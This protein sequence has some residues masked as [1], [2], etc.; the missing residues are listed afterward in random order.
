MYFIDL[1]WFYK[2]L[3]YKFYTAMML[4]EFCIGLSTVFFMINAELGTHWNISGD[5]ASTSTMELSHCISRDAML[6]INQRHR[7]VE[8]DREARDVITRLKLDRRRGCRAGEHHR[9]RVHAAQ[10]VTSSVRG[11]ALRQ[12]IPS[13]VGNRTNNVNSNQLIKK[14]LESSVRVP[15]LVTVQRS[16]TCIACTTDANRP[17]TTA[18]GSGRTL[19]FVPPALYV[20]NAAAVTK[21][22]AISHLTADLLGYNIDVGIITETHLK[23]NHADHTVSVHGFNLFR[24]DRAKRR[25]GGVAVYVSN[26]LSA[27]LWTPA[28]DHSDYELLWVRVQFNSYEAV[29]GALYHPPK[30]IYAVSD[31]LCHIDA[32]LD[33][34]ASDMPSAIVVIAGDFNSLSDDDFVSRTALASL[35]T[36]PTR[37]LNCLDRIYTNDACYKHV[38]VVTSAVKSDHCAVIA[39]DDDIP[40]FNINK[41][42]QVRTCRKRTPTQ[43]DAFL[44]FASRENIDFCSTDDVQANFDG[45]YQY[46]QELLNRF[47]P[48]R[49]VTIT[50][51]DPHFVTPAVKSM[52]R[53][54]NRLMRSGRV[55]EAAAI[56]KRVRSVITRNN[57]LH[58][59]NNDTRRNVRETWSKVRE[60]TRGRSYDTDATDSEF[61]ADALNNHYASISTDAAYVPT[62]RKQTVSN[63]DQFVTEMDVFHMLD[64]LK[65]TAA[66][67][68]G[69]PEW[70]LRVSA[71]VFAAPL[72]TLMNQSIAEGVVP[73]QWKTALI[74]PV[75]KV[76]EPTSESDYRPISITSILS[77]LVERRIVT[78]YIYP[79][80]QS[81]PPQLYFA[82]QY[83][84]RPTG[85]TTAAL[86]ALL[87]TICTMLSANPFVRVFAIDF[88]KAFDSIR[89]HQL[90]EKLSF[91]TIPDEIYNWVENFFSGRDHC[92]RFR[93]EMSTFACISASVVQ[94]SALGPASY[95]ITAANLRPV[96]SG[97]AIF[98]YA[99]DTY[100]VVPAANDDTCDEELKH[101]QAWADDN[102]L[103]MNATKS[104]E[105]I[106]KPRGARGKSLQLPPPF[107]TIERVTKMTVLGVIINDRLTSTDHVTELLV[108]CTKLIYAMRVLRTYGLPH[109]SLQDVFRATVEA[110]L[111]YA[112]PAWSGFST[113]ADR[114]RINSF[115]RRCL[116]LG[117][118]DSDSPDVDCMFADSDE[119]FFDRIKHNSRHILQQYLPDRP[120]LNY[121]LR[122]RHHNKTLISKTSELNDRDFII[123]NLYKYSY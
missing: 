76:A 95:A 57:S 110:K 105:I 34:I 9:R 10:V 30:P 83:A 104:K 65:P 72:A 1:C 17:T 61:T 102:N 108:S 22:H 59:H 111:L 39:Y 41:R 82:D 14:R 56:A 109:Q 78:S 44:Q 20:L 118:R 68:D 116:K 92:T 26:R 49:Q 90:L 77:R 51:S 101:I 4:L 12:G 32:C 21:P 50:T 62:R 122:S 11:A 42:R 114:S 16:N 43:H 36:M 74:V 87:H 3:V 28:S 88:S 37:G 52:L 117:Y 73:R 120:D 97:N 85:S 58:L 48:E 119:Q 107:P 64:R 81:P 69:L 80:M 18:V 55:E 13:I 27:S 79:A 84:F 121:S 45:M 15:V 7:Y 115:L 2:K 106:F 103:R 66:G 112:A 25:G 100:L 63:S 33:T 94:G 98:K 23:R 113:A 31:L 29:I 24:R 99:D 19:G 67:L 60:I 6:A 54:K 35:V 53:R 75:P 96:H 70:F 40:R 5:I 47:Y 86:I 89:H 123:R 8:L 91:L 71:P 93:D 46:M 38:K